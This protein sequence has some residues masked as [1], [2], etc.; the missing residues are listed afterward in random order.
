MNGLWEEGRLEG[1]P[2]GKNYAYVLSDPHQ[3][4]STDY[5]VLQSQ[6][7]DCFL[8]CM[9]LLYNGK[10]QLYYQTDGYRS[11]ASLLPTLEPEEF[12]QIAA[13][14]LKDMQN[15]KR[16]GFLSCAN[17]NL[18]AEHIYVEPGT[19]RTALLYLPAKL[20]FYP[21]ETGA[22]SELRAG[23]IKILEERTT[24]KSGI[25][26]RF[27]EELANG[28]LSLDELAAAA[29]GSRKA[30]EAPAP[31]QPEEKPGPGMQLVAL[32]APG[33]LTIAITKAEFV[34][35]KKAGQVDA[36]LDFNRMI[37]RVHCKVNRADEGYTV[38][39]LESANGTYVNR[40]RIRPAQPCPVEDGDII[41]MANTDF[42]VVIR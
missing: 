32:N 6:S 26:A 42:R 3:F 29:E 14:I 36:V 16:N 38:T 23:L 12:M 20:H 28:M 31:A 7:E 9:K 4:L 24:L 34:L 37:S 39:D 5:K 10:L 19:F 35:G 25:T 40:V 33:R 11:F 13:G 22:E 2:C 27:A 30:E 1:M 15:V 18:S 41:R 8:K 21:D 17:I